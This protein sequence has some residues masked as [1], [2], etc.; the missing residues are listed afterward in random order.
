[1]D[2][3]IKRIRILTQKKYGSGA[4]ALILIYCNFIPQ[5]L[6]K[7]AFVPLKNMKTKLWLLGRLTCVIMGRQCEGERERERERDQ[8]ERERYSAQETE[9]KRNQERKEIPLSIMGEE[10]VNII[11][12]IQT[13]EKSKLWVNDSLYEGK[14]LSL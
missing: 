8:N 10:Q 14:E 13:N 7:F 3:D 9:G 5:V 12:F 11:N 6:P 4:A 2:P 1:M